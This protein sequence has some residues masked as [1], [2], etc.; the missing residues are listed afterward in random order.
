TVDKDGRVF[1]VWY[2]GEVQ[3]AGVFFSVSEDRGKTFSR[4][5]AAH[6]EAK[7]SDHAQISAGPD[8][9]ISLIWDAKVGENRRVYWRVSNDHG[10][11][12]GP[13]TELET[14]A[15]AADYPAIA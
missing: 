4:T 7:I 2:A 5:I 1:A 14:P 3:P 8:G 12:F 10:K 9:T 6:P 15:G 13:V 11:T